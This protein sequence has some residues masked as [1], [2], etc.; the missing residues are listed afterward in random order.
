MKGSL[1]I[2]I[3][4]LLS[5]A[6]R[7]LRRRP[8]RRPSERRKPDIGSYVSRILSDAILFNET[9]APTDRE[10]RRLDF[11]VQRLSEF[12]YPNPQVDEFGNVGIVIPANRTTDDHALLFADIGSGADSSSDCLVTLEAGRARGKGLAENSVGVAA[13]LVLAEY[14]AAAG[15]SYDRNLALLFS[16]FDPGRQEMQPLERFLQDLKGR[17]L[18][19]AHVRSLTL[20]RIQ[21]RPMGTCKLSVTARTD[22]RDLMGAEGAA[23]AIS[24]LAAV[25]SRLGSIRWDSENN[26]FLNIARLE[27]GAGFGWYATEGVLELEIFSTDA[28]ALEVARKAVTATIGNIAADAEASAEVTVKT[29]YPA[30]NA[31]MNAGLNDA[32]RRV[33]ARLRI[34]PQPTSVPDHSAFINSLGIPSVSLG[35]TTGRRS[36]T[37]ESVDTRPIEA[38]FRQ[39][40]GFLDETAGCGGGGAP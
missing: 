34:K 24:V 40:L 39:L 2:R 23:S 12:G 32:L 38:G 30:G 8:G 4:E 19:A 33:Y 13:L 28:S 20:G 7:M 21:E 1:V 27:A 36:L 31:E 3:R 22:Q 6:K 17:F 16:S 18:F 37:E 26:T 25:A 5:T 14:I 29:F 11:I 35:I 15:L 9:P 10:N